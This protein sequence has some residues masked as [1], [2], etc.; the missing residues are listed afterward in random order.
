MRKVGSLPF[1]LGVAGLFRVFFAVTGGHRILHRDRLPVEGGMVLA[2]NHVSHLDPPA[3]ALALPR[4]RRLLALAKEEL[5]SNKPF[6]RLIEWIGAF[7]IRRGEGDSAAIKLAI[8]LV[9]E[10]HP[11]LVFPEGTR[12][13]GD[14]LLPLQPGPAMIARRTGRPVVPVGIAGTESILPAGGGLR[15][16]GRP[17][18]V[19]FGEPLDWSEYEGLGKGAR[20]AF[21]AELAR[22][23]GAALAEARSAL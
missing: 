19:A 1:Y 4:Q 8:E 13:D 5:W 23:I 7:P 9:A 3:L 14:A 18:V 6:G 2:P 12:G 11:L 15:R 10:G 22:R 16:S 17:V 20:E 21:Q